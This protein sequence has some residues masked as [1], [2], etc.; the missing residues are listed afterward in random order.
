MASGERRQARAGRAVELARVDGGE[1]PTRDFDP[2]L[3]HL[4]LGRLLSILMAVLAGYFFLVL[5][6]RALGWVRS[7]GIPRPH[8][9]PKSE[10]PGR[11]RRQQIGRGAWRGRGEISGG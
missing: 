5:L 10:G 7:G 8:R 11:D 6:H 2:P 9:S 4:C 3:S 1:R